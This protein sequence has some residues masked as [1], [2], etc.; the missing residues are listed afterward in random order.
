MKNKNI[1]GRLELVWWLFTL[2]LVVGVL[3]PI[4]TQVSDYPFY[5]SNII[6]IVVFITMARYMFL[7][8]YTF[9]ETRQVVKVAVICLC[10][11]LIFYLVQALNYMQTYID[12]H[13]MEEMLQ[14]VASARRSGLSTYIR[15]EMLLFGTGAIISAV[16]L[17]ARLLVSIW[18]RHNRV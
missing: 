17:P 10:V 15:N 2:V 8:P 4:Y 6:F 1:L 11:P 7:L 9:L 3:L 18:R 14:S 13:R 16:L 12:E 5:V